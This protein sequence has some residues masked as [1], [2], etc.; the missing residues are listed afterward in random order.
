MKQ[1]R[2]QRQHEQGVEAT[3]TSSTDSSGRVWSAFL[4]WP[5]GMVLTPRSPVRVAGW[6]MARIIRGPRFYQMPA[7]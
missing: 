1:G 6:G 4:L 2:R 5:D 3:C 7:G